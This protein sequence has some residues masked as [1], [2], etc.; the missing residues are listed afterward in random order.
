MDQL[1]YERVALIPS[2]VPQWMDRI[3]AR[4]HGSL[5]PMSALEALI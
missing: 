1:A 3:A 2:G 4:G 5:I